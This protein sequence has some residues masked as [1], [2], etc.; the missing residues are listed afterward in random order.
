MG[1]DDTSGDLVEQG[2]LDIAAAVGKG[3]FERVRDRLHSG[4]REKVV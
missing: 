2:L 1:I 3:D 4:A